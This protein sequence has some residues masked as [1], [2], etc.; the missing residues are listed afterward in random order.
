[1]GAWL[2]GVDWHEA[3]DEMM[4]PT[5]KRRIG[6]WLLGLF[7]LAQIAGIVPLVGA[8]LQ[9]II[10]TQRDI[11]S[12]LAD[13]G[14][15]NHVHRHHANHDHDRHDH[16]VSD[17]TDQCCTL[18]HHLAG[19]VPSIAGGILRGNLMAL[20]MAFPPSSLEGAEPTLLER[21][22]KLPLSI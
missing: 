1:L 18:H 15:A 4:S 9:H 3:I 11:A 13:T 19:V 12:D 5:T 14:V 6:P 22:P 7:F 10:E 17:S 21:P 2:I 8:H 16:G 20:L